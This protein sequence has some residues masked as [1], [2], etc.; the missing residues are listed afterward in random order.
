MLII[1]MINR[2][3]PLHTWR[4]YEKVQRAAVSNGVYRYAREKNPEKTAKEIYAQMSHPETISL[5]AKEW[6][7]LPTQVRQQLGFLCNDGNATGN[8]RKNVQRLNELLGGKLLRVNQTHQQVVNERVE[9][10][11]GVVFRRRKVNE[12][13]AAAQRKY[14]ALK[15]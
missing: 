7:E 13:Q 3:V 9:S 2:N 12:A 1:N 5:V 10:V 15:K 4:D 11:D 14:A 6:E 8:V